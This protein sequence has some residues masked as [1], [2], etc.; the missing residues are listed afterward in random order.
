MKDYSVIGKR[1]PRTDAMAKVTGEAKYTD[2]LRLPQMLIGKLLRSP[3]PHAKILHIDTSKAERLMGVKGVVTGLDTPKKKYGLLMRD[4]FMDRY[5]LA[6]DMVRFIGEEVAAVAAVDEDTALEALDLIR[7]EYEELPAVFNPEEA[8]KP[9]APSVHEGK[10]NAVMS[11]CFEYGDAEKGFRDSDYVREDKFATQ[12]VA[13]GCMETHAALGMVDFSGKVTLWSS[14]QSPFILCRDLAQTLNI[15]KAKIRVIK[16]FVGGGFG[17]KMEMLP[18]EFC[19]A[20][21]SI[22]TGKPVRIVH[23]REE[24]FIGTSQRHPVIIQ[25]KT[26]VKRDG[27]LVAKECYTI[28]DTGAY[29]THGPMMLYGIH[30]FLTMLYRVPNTKFQG[31]CVYTN[32]PVRGAM[33]GHGNP[34]IRFA[35]DSQLDLIAQ[36]LGIDPVEIRLKNGIKAGDATPSRLRINSCG[37]TEAI[38]RC[39]EVSHWKERKKHTGNKG[40]GIACGDH[41]SGGKLYEPYDSSS[42]FLKVEED[43]KV[44]ILSGASDI[45]QGLDSILCQ[46]VAEEF[47]IP[48][49]DVSIVAGDTE[50]TPQDLG[51]FGSRGTFLAGNACLLAARDARDQIFKTVAEKLETTVEDLEIKN[52]RI[53]VKGDLQRRMSLSEAAVACNGSVLGRGTYESNTEVPDRKGQGNISPAYSFGAQVAEVEVHADTGK[54]DLLRVIGAQDVG[55]ALNPMHIE[56]QIEGSVVMGQGQALYEE[57]LMRKGLTL[58]PS[59]LEYKVPTSL[60]SPEIVSLIVETHDPEGPYGAKGFSE[61]T[62]VPTLAAIANAVD[63]AIGVRIKELPM[64]PAKIFEIIERSNSK[65]LMRP[66]MGGRNGKEG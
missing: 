18:L 49:E 34:Q 13:H 17:G 25:L 32:N 35:D 52:G 43:G 14:T 22:K 31:Y 7:V 30:T 57:L 10:A 66:E 62:M 53:N 2:D 39:A 19:S 54:V 4:S 55:V 9:G 28:V 36:D 47:A 24:E 1:L 5:P 3:L 61:S 16:P 27:T 44:I 38:E 46:I 48:I 58:N 29:L 12:A 20:L 37:L 33:R 15:P 40:I 59:F 23:T 8:M 60:E 50:V 42:V 11:R 45:G 51:A 65:T 26:G 41:I 63:H 21:L 56:G 64:T 6:V